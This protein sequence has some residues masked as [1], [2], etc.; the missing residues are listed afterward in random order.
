MV[1]FYL[2]SYTGNTD[3][4]PQMIAIFEIRIANGVCSFLAT[5]IIAQ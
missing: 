1:N 2:R 3:S 4:E 5:K